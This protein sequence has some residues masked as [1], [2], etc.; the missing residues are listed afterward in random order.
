MLAPINIT[1]AYCSSLNGHV[2]A[3]LEQK[4]SSVRKLC[5]TVFYKCGHTKQHLCRRFEKSHFELYEANQK[6]GTIKE[7]NYL[8]I[9]SFFQIFELFITWFHRLLISKTPIYVLNA[10]LNL[11]RRVFHLIPNSKK[12]S[13]SISNQIRIPLWFKISTKL[14]LRIYY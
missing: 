12:R 6:V 9:S 8:H 13:A 5:L 4:P 1:A 14:V 7:L 2:K 10:E 11:V 3:L